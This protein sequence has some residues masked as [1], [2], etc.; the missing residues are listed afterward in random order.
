MHLK[1]Q[2]ETFV[3]VGENIYT[4]D[5]LVTIESSIARVPL[6]IFAFLS[7]CNTMLSIKC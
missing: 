4:V 2:G 5:L 3:V 1:F 6:A 7:L